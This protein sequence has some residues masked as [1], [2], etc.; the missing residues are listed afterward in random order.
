VWSLPETEI[1]YDSPIVYY[2]LDHPSDLTT[3]PFYSAVGG[4]SLFYQKSPVDGTLDLK[5]GVG[6]PYDPYTCPTWARGSFGSNPYLYVKDF[7]QT[8][9]STFTVELLVKVTQ[10]AYSETA[11]IFVDYIGTA[12]NIYYDTVGGITADG[13]GVTLNSNAVNFLDGNVHLISVVS[14][15]GFCGLYV[16][17][18]LLDSDTGFSSALSRKAQINLGSYYDGEISHFAIYPSALSATAVAFHA[19][20]VDAYYGETI[21]VGLDAVARWSGVSIT[22]EGSGS[23]QLV[24]A[25]DTTDKKALDAL[26]LLSSG[27][28]GVLYDNGSGLYARIGS[29]LKSSTVELSLDVEADLNGSVTLTRS[30]TEDTAGATVS[31]YSQS[32]TYVDAAQA[33]AIGTYASADAPNSLVAPTLTPMCRA[34]PNH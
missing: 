20:A 5:S 30:I 4:A 34:G 10:N 3:E 7:T 14:G 25:I 21:K 23:P 12:L 31:S 29:Q 32:A 27:D 18:V 2:T 11:Y 28:G 33:A 8:D 19:S 16:D 6:A 26:A 15:S 24:D 13:L 9:L 22:H 17:G 1:R